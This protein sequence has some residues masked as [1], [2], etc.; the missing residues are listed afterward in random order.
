[1]IQIAVAHQMQQ[2]SKTCC[3]QHQGNMQTLLGFEDLIDF[4][5]NLLSQHMPLRLTL[6]TYEEEFRPH[7]GV[8]FLLVLPS[9]HQK[10]GK[11][12]IIFSQQNN[13]LKRLNLPKQIKQTCSFRVSMVFAFLGSCCV[14]AAASKNSSGTKCCRFGTNL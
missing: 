13:T 10:Y 3:W 12:R 1:M 8:Q 9:P 14:K 2:V 6:C 4:G 5:V 7:S 11:R